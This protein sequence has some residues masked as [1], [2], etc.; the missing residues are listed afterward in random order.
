MTRLLYVP[1]ERFGQV[2]DQG[3]DCP[4]QQQEKG[5]CDRSW[6]ERPEASFFLG[7]PLH[8]YALMIT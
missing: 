6:A 5:I 3:V 2:A 8:N 4:D 7:W 1:V